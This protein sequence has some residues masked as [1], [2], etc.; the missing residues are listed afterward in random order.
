MLNQGIRLFSETNGRNDEDENEPDDLDQPVFSLVTG[1]YRHA[2]RY[3][4][5][6]VPLPVSF[7]LYSRSRS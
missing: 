6:F 5:E 4:S 1:K 7:S 2:K 3:H